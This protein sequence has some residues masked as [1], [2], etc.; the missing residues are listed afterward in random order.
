MSKLLTWAY[1]YLKQYRIS[2]RSFGSHI[3]YFIIKMFLKIHSILEKFKITKV[4]IK[5]KPINAE[6]YT[7]M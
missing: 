3:Q 4:Y 7:L 1:Q 5:F 6:F 2:R